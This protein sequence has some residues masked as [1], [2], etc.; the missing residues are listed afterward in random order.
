[1]RLRHYILLLLLLTALPMKSVS[2][3][4]EFIQE[5][6][7]HL[8]QQAG[9]NSELF[10][11]PAA[12]VNTLAWFKSTRQVSVLHGIRTKDQLISFV[13]RLG[14]DKYMKTDNR[15]GTSLKGLT[16]GLAKYLSEC[17]I[18]HRIEVR[19]WFTVSPDT[20][21]MSFGWLSAMLKEKRGVII[22]VG[23]YNEDVE[24]KRYTRNGGH[25]VTATGYAH[26]ENRREIVF[27]DPLQA[28]GGT[29]CHVLPLADGWT[30]GARMPR[31]EADE[32]PMLLH[33]YQ[34]AAGRCAIV[35]YVITYEV[36]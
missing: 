14:S 29:R 9:M 22:N 31:P 4:E 34:S 17:S 26:D 32:R 12:V 3:G 18:P 20:P 35:E 19:P 21:P 24:Q 6:V 13:N 23:W 1:V 10:C 30:V 2:A 7:P 11:G 27:N 28:E 16:T 8:S 25:F 33:G 36:K 5:N 15:T